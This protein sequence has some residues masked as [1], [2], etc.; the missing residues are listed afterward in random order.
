MKHGHG[1]GD[2]VSGFWSWI[3]VFGFEAS[4]LGVSMV[5]RIYHWYILSED[6][7]YRYA[8]TQNRWRVVQT[9]GKSHRSRAVHF[10]VS[11][12]WSG[13]KLRVAVGKC[14]AS[15][16]LVVAL[17]FGDLAL[18]CRRVDCPCWTRWKKVKR[19]NSVSTSCEDDCSAREEQKI[20]YLQRK[21]N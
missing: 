17:Q 20:F 18:R 8:Q 3:A 7:A 14:Q 6:H 11:V 10:H 12:D 2:Y 4:K 5:L 1:G 9:V 16:R 19:L 13:E 15:Y 21:K